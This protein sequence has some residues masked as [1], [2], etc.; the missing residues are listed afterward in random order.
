MCLFRMDEEYVS[1]EF[2]L[3]PRA[4]CGIVKVACKIKSFLSHE[5][6]DVIPVCIRKGVGT[7]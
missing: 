7:Y 6:M 1:L 3:I 2:L 4:R 5:G